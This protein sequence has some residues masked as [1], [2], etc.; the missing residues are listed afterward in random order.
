MSRIIK[1]E[2]TAIHCPAEK[3]YHFISNFNNFGHLMPEQV[4]N[5]KAD[6]QS[7]SFEVKGIA[8]LGL[9]ITNKVPF[10]LISMKGEGKIPFGFTFDTHINQTDQNNCTVEI[11][12]TAD[13]NPFI[14]MMAEKPLQNLV[15]MMMPRLKTEM[16]K[17]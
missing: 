2:V 4:V 6:D 10:S 15:D 1:S 8:T 3:V 9:R 11:K 14:A 5:W 12:I 17:Q 7:C 13:M 16:E